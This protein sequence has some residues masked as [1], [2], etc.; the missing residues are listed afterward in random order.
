MRSSR[1][2][3]STSA[4]ASTKASPVLDALISTVLDWAITDSPEAAARLAQLPRASQVE[5]RV[6]LRALLNLREPGPIP[7]A[8]QADLDQLL[9]A[10]LAERGVVAGDQL[11]ATAADPRL[12]LWRGDITRLQVDAIVNAANSALLGCFVPLHRCIDNAIGSAAGPG[13]RN[14]CAAIMAQ[15]GRPEPTGTATLT[16]G[17]CLPAAHVI[18]TVGPIVRGELTDNHEAQLVSCYRSCL[19][20]MDDAGLRSI[21][22][23]CISTG[24]FGYPKAPAARTAVATV[25]DYL[26]GETGIERVIFNVFTDEDLATYRQLLGPDA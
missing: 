10:E 22:L 5:R 7:A 3:I 26:A 25:R 1:P 18:H 20:A 6:L 17:Y 19:Q 4:S 15:R 12:V 14:E 8:I 24:E 21:A 9:A 2:A 13:L 11:P 16:G 23:C